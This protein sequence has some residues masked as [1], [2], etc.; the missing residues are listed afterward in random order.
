[1]SANTLRDQL[2]KVGGEIKARFDAEKRVL[3][4]SEY[5][6]LFAAHPER[7][8]RD[9]SRYVRDAFD[10]FGSYDVERAYGSYRR[11]REEHVRRVHDSWT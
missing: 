7:H 6:D 4:F 5:L 9:A 8:S 2:K 1:M 10:Y 3:S 11:F